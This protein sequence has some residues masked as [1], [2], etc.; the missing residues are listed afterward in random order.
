MLPITDLLVEMLPDADRVKPEFKSL[1]RQEPGGAITCPYCQGAVEYDSDGKTLTV[2]GRFPLRYSRR[3]T[4]IRA[5]DYGMQKT[6]PDPA[7]TPVLWIAE[8]KIMP[9]ALQ[10]YAYAEDLVP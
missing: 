3:K 8:E 2:S 9:G 5:T 7:M 10:G 4:E 6:P 1:L